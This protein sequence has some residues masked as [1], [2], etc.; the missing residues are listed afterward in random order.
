[1]SEILK[2]LGIDTPKLFAQILIFGIVYLVLKKY[3]FGPVTKILDERQRRL[4][5]GEE[6]LKRIKH[7][8]ASSEAQAAAVLGKANADADRIVKEA[9][10]AAAAIAATERQKALAEGTG[11]IAKSREASELERNRIMAELKRDFGRLVVETTARV[12]GKALTEKDQARLNKEALA[13]ISN[14]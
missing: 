9:R 13:Q 11:I 10:E 2:Q 8:L 3:A 14:N 4:A 7:N 12:S 6:N 1:M 5:E